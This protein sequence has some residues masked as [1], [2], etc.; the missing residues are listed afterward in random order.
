MVAMFA[1]KVP[2]I[3]AGHADAASVTAEL[4]P[5]NGVIV[6]VEDPLD[7]AT[8]ETALALSVKLGAALTVRAIA[9]FAVSAPLVPTTVSE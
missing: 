1:A 3:P 4:N 7:P 2:V 6:T 8:A 5:F 9:V